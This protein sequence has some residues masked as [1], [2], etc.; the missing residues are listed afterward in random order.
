MIRWFYEKLTELKM[1]WKEAM[2][3]NT[4]RSL[5]LNGNTEKGDRDSKLEPHEQKPEAAVL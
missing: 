1:K 3:L 5:N 2:R 4:V